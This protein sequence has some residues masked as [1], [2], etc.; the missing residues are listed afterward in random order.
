MTRTFFG[1][2]SA[3]GLIEFRGAI[4]SSV[5]TTTN[6][7]TDRLEGPITFSPIFKVPRQKR[8]SRSKA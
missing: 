8:F 5:L 7:E 3:N 4:S 1:I 2:A 6:V